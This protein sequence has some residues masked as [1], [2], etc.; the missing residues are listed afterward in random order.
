M[1]IWQ[2]IT[3]AE[4]KESIEADVIHHDAAGSLYFSLQIEE[5]EYIICKAYA[6]RQWKTINLT[7]L[8]KTKTKQRTREKT[9]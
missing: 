4:M 8:T 3:E 2:I 6:A 7:S 1:P 9:Q 5:N